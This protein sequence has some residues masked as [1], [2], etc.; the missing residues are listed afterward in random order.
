MF[1]PYFQPKNKTENHFLGISGSSLLFFKL[2]YLI[3]FFFLKNASLTHFKFVETRPRDN[4]ILEKQSKIC[5]LSY[6]KDRIALFI[7]IFWRNKINFG[8]ILPIF[9][10]SRIYT[11]KWTNCTN[12]LRNACTKVNDEN[13]ITTLDKRWS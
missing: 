2:M 5:R 9:Q 8:K 3:L 10:Y 11:Y 1:R 6:E 12:K 4:K 13:F 7:I